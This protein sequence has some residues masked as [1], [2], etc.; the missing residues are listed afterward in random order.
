MSEF[1]RLPREAF[2]GLA[3]IV[4][5]W[6]LPMVIVSNA[7]AQMLL[8]GF[9]PSLLAWVLGIATGWFAVTVFVFNRGL[10]RY[11]SASS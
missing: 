3:N 4:F 9:K 11:S 8:H 5:V 1:S 7:P 10:R 6:A 2:K